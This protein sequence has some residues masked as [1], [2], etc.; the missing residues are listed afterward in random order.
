MNEFENELEQIKSMGIKN[1]IHKGYGFLFE[2]EQID[3]LIF[4]EIP[5]K[6]PSITIS[7]CLCQ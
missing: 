3:V 4:V 7:S 5:V 2:H 6:L 1:S